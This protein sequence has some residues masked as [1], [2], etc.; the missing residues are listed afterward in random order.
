MQALLLSAAGGLLIFFLLYAF[1]PVSERSIVKDRFSRYFRSF[2]IDD[3]RVQVLK[4]RHK[5]AKSRPQKALGKELTNYLSMSGVSLSGREFLMIWSFTT[6]IPIF[7]VFLLGG[8]AI[9][10]SGL[11]LIGFF[12]PPLFIQRSRKKRQEEFSKQLGEALV[13]MGNCIRSGF[14]FQQAMESIAKEM[15]PPISTEFSRA[16]REMHY[17]VSMKDALNHMVDRVKSQ[18]LDLLVTAVLTSSQVGG[19]LSEILDVISET[20][21]D[22][23]K[24]KAEVRVLTSSGRSSGMII[25]LLP[26]III[27]M[28]MVLNP[29][30][31]GSF[32]DSSIGKTMMIISAVLELTGFAII[33]K[34]VDIKY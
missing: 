3:V 31:F 13:L 24:I 6:F 28:L 32:F 34:I 18:D 10:A 26:I 29:Q 9:T 11:G 2:G 19:N 1:I 8:H 15:Q 4:E 30:Y 22:R 21:R 16:V 33:N 25:G 27:L 23:I 20:V 14:S 5:G 17:G 12:A 7:T